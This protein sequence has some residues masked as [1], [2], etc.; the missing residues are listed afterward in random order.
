MAKLVLACAAVFV[1]LAVTVDAH[2]VL[3]VP[4]VCGALLH[5][6]MIKNLSPAQGSAMIRC[7][8]FLRVPVSGCVLCT[9]HVVCTFSNAF[10]SN[11]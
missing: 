11:D 6:F 8:A 5:M 9:L 1:V 10:F 3:K 4:M 7:F 2:A